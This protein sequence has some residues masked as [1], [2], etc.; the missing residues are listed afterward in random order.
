MVVRFKP[1]NIHTSHLETA[2]KMNTEQIINSLSNP[3]IVPFPT[4]AIQQAKQQWPSLLATIDDLMDKFTR[5]ETLS[6]PEENLLFLGIMLLIDRKE[7][8]RFESLT[9]LLLAEKNDELTIEN[10]LGDSLTEVLP[11]GLYILANGNSAPLLKMLLS[12][13]IEEFT[14]LAALHAILQQFHKQQLGREELRRHL[15]S[16]I[17]NVVDRDFSYV[18][19]D[20]AFLL[21][22]N[23][24]DEFKEQFIRLEQQGLFDSFCISANTIHRWESASFEKDKL[25]EDNFDIMSL[26][27]WAGFNQNAMAKDGDL[28]HSLLSTET[29]YI[30]P[31]TPGRNEPCPCGS[32]KKYK[33]CCLP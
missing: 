4:E 32:G 5:G 18:L 17:D 10:L 25:L 21:I 29:P 33:K 3:N 31:A 28:S 20:I 22:N 30:A 12:T 26:S 16:I 27:R 13:T 8:S 11:S 9:T 24:F 23:G 14:A 19:A 15:P 1:R 2:I 6:A 7:T